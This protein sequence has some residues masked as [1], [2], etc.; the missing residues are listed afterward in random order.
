[1]SATLRRAATGAPLLACTVAAV[2]LAGCVAGP[3]L[4]RSSGAADASE[5]R[6]ADLSLYFETIDRL[7]PGDA[8]RQAAEFA[9]VQA[10]V[11]QSPTAANRLR[12]ALALGAAGHVVSN[13]VEARRI[14]AELLAG[15]HDLRPTE[16]LLATAYQREFDARVEL[17]A[18]LARQR[19]D[20]EKKLATVDAEGDRRLATANAEV[21]KLRK[22]LAE[23]ERKLEAIA[24][25]ERMLAPE[26]Q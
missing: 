21:Q 25:V 16:I 20:A 7:A 24:E 18:E 12:Y 1:M 4:P 8:T 5:G 17:Y 15:P 13:P 14:I 6:P 22:A 11:Q 19:E 2:A 9:A 10:A 23:A 3:S 26:R